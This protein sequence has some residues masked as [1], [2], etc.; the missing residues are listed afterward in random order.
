[1]K[2]QKPLTVGEVRAKEKR[3]R[4]PSIEEVLALV[5]ED[6]DIFCKIGNK[7][8]E[9]E[10]AQILQSI[11]VYLNDSE[12]CV[13]TREEAEQKEREYNKEG[14]KNTCIYP[15]R[16]GYITVCRGPQGYT[17]PV[18]TKVFMK[19]ADKQPDLY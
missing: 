6:M 10:I 12:R 14:W 4:V 16:G 19:W 7:Q 13:R 3:L 8:K 11:Q 15:F 2:E 1:M 5:D 9:Q 17:W 18:A